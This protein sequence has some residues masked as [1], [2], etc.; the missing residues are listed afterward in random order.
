MS[1]SVHISVCFACDDND[2]VADLARRHM[3]PDGANT[4]ARLFLQ[5]LASRSGPNDGPKGGLSMWGIVGNYTDEDQFIDALRPFW[6][7]L[8]DDVDGGPCAIE[9]V[10]VFV[11]HSQARRAAAIEIGLDQDGMLAV[12]KHLCPFSWGVV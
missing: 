5:T 2:P 9:H 4:E 3:L 7:A 1:H 10:L 6:R 8:L 12:T 11:E